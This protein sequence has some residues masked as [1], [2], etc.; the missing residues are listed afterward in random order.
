MP[1]ASEYPIPPSITKA[2]L[3][4]PT[5]AYSERGELF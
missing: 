1:L 3:V 5:V 4:A 2:R